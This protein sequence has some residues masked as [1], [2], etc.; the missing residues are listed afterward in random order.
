MLP[1]Y[2]CDGKEALAPLIFVAILQITQICACM[3][4]SMEEG[5]LPKR[6]LKKQITVD[7][8]YLD[9]DYLE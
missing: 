8:R 9:F 2:S 5:V 4:A 1:M 7:P 3:S 6:S